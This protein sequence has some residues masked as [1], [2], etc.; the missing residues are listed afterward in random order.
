MIGNVPPR[1]RRRRRRTS[2]S[3]SG[4]EVLTIAPCSA[5]KRPSAEAWRHPSAIS[6][7]TSSRTASSTGPAGVAHAITVGASSHCERVTPAMKPPTSW[8]ASRQKSRRACPFVRLPSINFARSQ[9]KATKVLDSCMSPPMAI[10]MASIPSTGKPRTT[11]QPDRGRH[12]RP[13]AAVR[14]M[15][16]PRILALC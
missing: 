2:P 10:R 8:C 14:V 13:Y 4:Y 6:S 7:T 5:S 12:S 11:T 1:S 16:D 3:A 9:G 15:A